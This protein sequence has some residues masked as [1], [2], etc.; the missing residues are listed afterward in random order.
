MFMCSLWMV[1]IIVLRWLQPLNCCHLKNL[2]MQSWDMYNHI[3]HSYV[4]ALKI[5]LHHW[6]ITVSVVLKAY[7]DLIQ[8]TGSI[9]NKTHNSHLF[10]TYI[11]FINFIF[12][13]LI[14]NDTFWILSCMPLW[15]LCVYFH[16]FFDLQFL[17]FI[18]PT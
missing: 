5:N 7:L 8:T 2:N 9:L 17:H 18:N 16:F 14:V 12:C 1:L 6:F 11:H 4:A 15:S 10:S 13:Y 3:F